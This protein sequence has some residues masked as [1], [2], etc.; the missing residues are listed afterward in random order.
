MIKGIFKLKL[1]DSIEKTTDPNEY[2]FETLSAKF[3]FV[4]LAGSERLKRTGATGH[5]AKEGICINRGLLALGN[6]ISALGDRDKRGSHV[7][8]RDSK[9]TRLLQDSL[10]GNSRTLMIACVSPSDRDF[11]ETLNTLRY[12]NR[13]RNIKNRVSV[14]QDTTSQQIS[15]LKAEIERLNYELMQYK[16]KS[17]SNK[18]Q[19]VSS[20]T[21][22][23]ISSSRTTSTATIAANSAF[24]GQDHQSS[25]NDFFILFNDLKQENDLLLRE[26][27]NLRIRIKAMHETVDAVKTR[28]CDLE[29][30]T[31]KNSVPEAEQ[32]ILASYIKQNENLR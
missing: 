6:V 26:N 31:A 12:A 5:R 9:L 10:G 8:Y 11:M 3:H 28:N 19:F 1:N 21:S 23:S 25:N 32:N 15:L 27:Q 13:A 16:S 29:L 22:N 30:L 17:N 20:E 7:P 14:N 18:S 2:E 24:N 4:D